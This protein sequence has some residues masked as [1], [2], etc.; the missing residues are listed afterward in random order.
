[1]CKNGMQFLLDACCVFFMA[2]SLLFGFSPINC[3]DCRRCCEDAVSTDLYGLRRE[4]QHDCFG[5]AKLDC[6]QLPEIS[7]KFL[8]QSSATDDTVTQYQILSTAPLKVSLSA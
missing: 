2:F 3:C 4:I 5:L 7:I 8:F 6:T 1:M